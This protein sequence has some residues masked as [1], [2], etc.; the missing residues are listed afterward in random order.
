LQVDRVTRARAFRFAVA[1]LTTGVAAATLVIL[2]RQASPQQLEDA[3]RSADGELLAL[4]VL[5]ALAANQLA[6][7]AR[8]AR[9]LPGRS[10]E[11]PRL[12]HVISAV[13]L[14]QAAN[15]VLPL[16]AGEA[17]RT[18]EVVRRGVPLARVVS[19]QVLEKAIEAVLVAA[20]VAPAFAVGALRRAGVLPVAGI[21]VA[22]LAAIGLVAWLR[23]RRNW[24]ARVSD[25]P[26]ADL[27][28]S[29]AWAVAADATEVLVI[30]LTARSLGLTLGLAGSLAVLGS[31]N[32]AIALPSTPANVG[33]LECGAAAALL[34]LGVAHEDA[35]A[36]AVLYRIVQFVPVSL[37]GAAIVAIRGLPGAASL[38]KGSAP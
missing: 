4:G 14:A 34:G 2:A 31:V 22:V 35:L 19:A 7:S 33:T 30:A 16:R 12:I 8:F 23:R 13:V 38:R 24:L 11:R 25:W 29:I 27:V 9:L 6:R 5:P 17:V 18:R 36:F 1:A 3:L 32:L 10:G 21:A 20:I 28:A 26:R 15:N 37:G